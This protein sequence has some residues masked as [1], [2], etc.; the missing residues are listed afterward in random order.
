MMIKTILSKSKHMADQVLFY[1]HEKHIHVII[2]MLAHLI[3]FG[4]R[5]FGIGDGNLSFFR[6]VF[7]TSIFHSTSPFE[8]RVFARCMELGYAISRFRAKGLPADAEI[9]VQI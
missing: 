5:P 4:L 6:L 8:I 2:A 7:N 3:T 1:P 9:E